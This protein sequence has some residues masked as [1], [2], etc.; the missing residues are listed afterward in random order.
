MV[1]RVIG[2]ELLGC[3]NR[4]QQALVMPEEL[5]CRLPQNTTSA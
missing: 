3:V 1:Y 5:H 2:V 4:I